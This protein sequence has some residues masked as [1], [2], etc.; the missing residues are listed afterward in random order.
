[1]RQA[2]AAVAA[3]RA[4]LTAAEAAL[5]AARVQLAQTELTAP[6]AGSVARL[7][8]EVGELAAP[9]TPAVV[10]ADLEAWQVETTDLAEADVVLVRAGQPAT[11]TLDAL[12]G[13]SLTAEVTAISA[14]AETNRGNVTYA[15][16]L[17]LDAAQAPLRW[18]MTAFVDITVR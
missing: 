16:T 10:L 8:L 12:P 9:G 2:E 4:G 11:V 6:F 18:G 7:N 3:A 5:E 13:Q 15:V 17:A 14:L 1:V